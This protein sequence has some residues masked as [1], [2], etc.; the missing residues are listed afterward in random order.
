MEARRCRAKAK[1]TGQQCKRR[2]IPFG[3]VCV[4]HGG[5]APQVQAKAAQRVRDLLAD[6]IDPDRVLRETARIAY[7][8]IGDIYDD[9]GNLLPIKQ[10]PEDARRAFASLEVVKQNL[11]AGDGKVDVVMK[12]RPWDKPKALEMLAKHNGLLNDKVDVNI[13]VNIVERL[14]AGRVRLLNARN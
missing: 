12:P 2:P 14:K 3:T 8:D 6:A 13:T 7:Q 9:A 5:G 4:K 10:W 1:G 11:T